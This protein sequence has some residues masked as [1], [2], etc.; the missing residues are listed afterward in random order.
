MKEL[1]TTSSVE[2]Q[3]LAECGATERC[4]VMEEHRSRRLDRMAVVAE[5][6]V[7]EGAQTER[8]VAVLQ[9]EVAK[10][11][12]AASVKIE[13]CR[14]M[15]R[16]AVRGPL[17]WSLLA[18][19][20][21]SWAWAL[22]PPWPL[23]RGRRGRRGQGRTFGT[24]R[25]LGVGIAAVGLRELVLRAQGAWP[26]PSEWPG[27]LAARALRALLG[28]S[29]WAAAAAPA[30]AGGS[31]S[32]PWMWL[33][34]LLLQ[35]PKP[36][37]AEPAPA[38]AAAG[39]DAGRVRLPAAQPPQGP[40]QACEPRPAPTP[41]APSPRPAP[42][43]ASSGLADADR[44]GGGGQSPPGCRSSGLGP[45]LARWSLCEHEARLMA[46]GYDAE[47]LA[48]MTGADVEEMMTE[49][50]CKPGHRVKFRKLFESRP[51]AI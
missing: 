31:S 33:P 35:G 39:T 49:I 41:P 29:G 37:P 14:E 13:E 36:S 1:D 46:L 21:L 4:R 6:S 10:E 2:R 43:S 17:A 9:A 42:P 8:Q 25:L 15:A 47:V 30:A 48:M 23:G 16:G 44:G 28:A 19:C 24:G 11:V 3:R 50:D 20:A 5:V 26:Q 34:W 12:V 45:L 51:Q 32:L 7:V 38:A 27:L 18:A 40:E 22:L